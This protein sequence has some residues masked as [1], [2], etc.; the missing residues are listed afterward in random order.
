MNPQGVS[1]ILL[2]AGLSSRMGRVNKLALPVD[3][4][5]L[6]RRTA[7]TLCAAGLNEVLVVLG[8]GAPHAEQMLAGLPVRTLRNPDYRVGQMSSVHQGLAAL[9]GPCAGVMVCLA[10]QPLLTTA[11]IRRIA[12]AFVTECPRPVLVP[13]W[14]GR[15]G[16]PIVMGWEQRDAILAGGRNL[17]CKRLIEKHP[18]LVWPLPMDNDHCVFDLDSPEDYQRLRFRLLAP[19]VEPADHASRASRLQPGQ[20]QPPVPQPI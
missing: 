7:R 15:R 9:G 19:A 2:A 8:H 17:G 5:P 3:G 13:I 12:G 6:L 20:G 1:A 11:D 16:N 14:R 4:E 18:A 10:D